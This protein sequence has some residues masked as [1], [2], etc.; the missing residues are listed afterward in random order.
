MEQFNSVL[1]KFKQDH[2]YLK[3]RD[4]FLN[5]IINE[6][7]YTWISN[8]RDYSESINDNILKALSF[9]FEFWRSYSTDFESARILNKTALDLY[10]SKPN[11]ENLLGYLTIINNLLIE[12]NV[13]GDLRKSYDYVSKG[14]EIAKRKDAELKYYIAFSNNYTYLL[15]ELG[16]YQS[17][18]DSIKDVFMHKD[19]FDE[20][21]K[22]TTY[23]IYIKQLI[24]TKRYDDAFKIVTELL[25]YKFLEKYIPT[26]VIERYF[27]DIGVGM[28]NEFLTELYYKK[29][30]DF[31]EED[32]TLTL[33]SLNMMYS[34]AKYA[35]IK[36]DLEIAKKYL[37]KC[38][39]NIDNFLGEKRNVLEDLISLYTKLNDIDKVNEI[40]TKLLKE[41]KEALDTL[42]YIYTKDTASNNVKIINETYKK[43]YNISN[44]INK[45]RDKIGSTL[46]VYTLRDYINQ[47]LKPLFNS[48]Y[49]GI[50][51]YS[52]SM[53][54]FT[55]FNG[56]NS[57]VFNQNEIDLLLSLSNREVL[58]KEL[59]YELEANISSIINYPLYNIDNTLIGFLVI[60]FDLLHQNSKELA[61][62]FIDE[63]IT[64][65][66]NALNNCQ[67]YAKLYNISNL[68]PLT[69]VKNRYGLLN[70][71]EEIKN[72]K[73]ITFHIFM[74]DLDD[75]KK[76]NDNFGHDAG[77]KVLVSF[78]KILTKYFGE[79]VVR[80]GGE[81]F[82]SFYFKESSK[83]NETITNLLNEVKNTTINENG[84]EITFTTSCG[85]AFVP[86][87]ANY[88]ESLKIADKRLYQAKNSG[89]NK[90]IYFDENDIH[91]K[92]IKYIENIKESEKLEKV[93]YDIILEKDEDKYKEIQ[94]RRQQIFLEDS[95]FLAEFN[96]YLESKKLNLN[97]TIY[98]A[99][100]S[101]AIAI[102]SISKAYDPALALEIHHFLLAYAKE[103]NDINLIIEEIYHIG[104]CHY[105]ISKTDPKHENDEANMIEKYL[106]YYD[107]LPSVYKIFFIK[108]MFNQML[109]AKTQAVAERLAIESR[110][111]ELLNYSRE[112]YKNID[113]DYNVALSALY[114]NGCQGISD[115]ILGDE[116]DEMVITF[117]EINCRE[118]YNL[119]GSFA[120]TIYKS[121]A[122]VELHLEGINYLKGKY[123][124]FEYAEV[125]KKLSIIN[126]DDTEDDI[127]SKQIF[128]RSFY[129]DFLKIKKL[130]S[131]EDYLKEVLPIIDEEVSYLKKL[132]N[133]SDNLKVNN[134]Y[135]TMLHTIMKQIPFEYSKKYFI[136]MTSFRNISTL[137]HSLSVAA[138][139]NLIFDEAVKVNSSYFNGIIDNY[140]DEEIFINKDKIKECLYEMCI[141]H[142]IGKYQL[143][144]IISNNYRPLLKS[145]R[146]AIQS[147][148]IIGYDMLNADSTPDYIKDA[149]LL[150]HKYYD[151]K[152][153]YP[154]NE[155]T[156]NLPLIS[157]LSI[158]DS[159]DA[160]T[161]VIGRCYA[162]NKT[163][164]D[165]ILEFNNE[166]D[167]RYSSFLVE[168]IQ[169]KDIKE[170]IENILNNERFN[171]IYQIKKKDI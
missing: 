171:F 47:E 3:L 60:G 32:P 72:D 52:E 124:D 97:P 15:N 126:E 151:G 45:F 2:D 118:A 36:S 71:I 67:N 22:L 92:A 89:K 117:F 82:I 81:E 154:D 138:I 146:K 139:S 113:Y 147:H 100:K 121:K 19:S 84:N 131:S 83:V 30:N 112:N 18:Y 42:A 136:E 134:S 101:L 168:L 28:K 145:E 167:T 50:I 105:N 137:I 95:R 14:L 17:A 132:M 99:L 114:R 54:A 160:A 157:I 158:A 9:A 43:L 155:H 77:D 159:I 170:K 125:L 69:G 5:N 74:F 91:N 149:V 35:L 108:A 62:E 127:M 110:C 169:R 88:D 120:K 31:L 165:L 79:N 98:E 58:P 10:E 161:D 75:F 65:I 4:F 48:S 133:N 33:D 119:N 78:T 23:N 164:D 163:L 55:L 153:G 26:V 6:N 102:N 156:N 57:K 11:Y 85:I 38:Y 13:L 27:I 46:N 24:L 162:S 142:N 39:E 152:G 115:Y 20:F 140:Q 59:P 61:F 37:D 80:M 56:Y 64:S 51:E 1:E 76:V 8:I 94:T 29:V 87:L 53:K 129:I 116:R 135:L 16:L 44:K 106:V 109:N 148:T 166:K 130:Y 122:S 96:E 128:I 12:A 111:L 34:A 49:L 73:N 123:T 141:F 66:A 150:H 40:N 68:D 90:Y 93:I 70:L 63:S 144:K 104:I 143:E 107:T 86:T 41:T 7:Y 21:N 25:N 103:I